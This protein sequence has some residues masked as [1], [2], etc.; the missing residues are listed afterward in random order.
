MCITQSH[1]T[2]DS[3]VHGILPGK[4]T[5]LGCCWDGTW[6]S[7]IAGRFFTIWATWINALKTVC[8][9]LEEVVR[10][11]IV[12][13]QSGEWD[14]LKDIFLIGWW[15][16][17]LESGSWTFW[18]QMAWGLCACRQLAVN[19]FYLVGGFNICKIAQRYC[20]VYHLKGNQNPVPRLYYCFLL[21]FPCLCVPS[22]PWLAT[23]GT[24]PV[25]PREGLG[26]CM[27]PTSCNQEMGNAEKL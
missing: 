11:F 10:S 18:L 27:K 20:Y 12:I 26:G 14:Q 9:D 8:P 13:V 4:N 5:G 19:F 15:W 22:L 2:L 23:V 1:P 21:L 6:V 3:S 7:C 17:N 25:G 24:C 16:G